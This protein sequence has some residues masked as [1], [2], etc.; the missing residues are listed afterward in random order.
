MK[1]ILTIALQK[2]TKLKMVFCRKS[3][4][5]QLRIIIKAVKHTLSMLN[6]TYKCDATGKTCYL[7]KSVLQSASIYIKRLRHSLKY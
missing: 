4:I 3:E 5:T 2:N 6:T 1:V 7:Y